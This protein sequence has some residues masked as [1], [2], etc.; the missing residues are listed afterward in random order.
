MKPYYEQDGITIY[1][2]DSEVMVPLL[3]LPEL[4]VTDPPYGIDY[5]S[6]KRVTHQRMKK[7]RGDKEFPRWVLDIAP[8]IALFI[9]CR[10]D[11]LLANM[12]APKSFIVWDKGV[13][14]M[15]DVCH[16]YGRQWEGCAFY[17]GPDHA[18]LKRPCDIIRINKIPP[19]QLCHPNEKPSAAI[20]PLIVAHRGDVLDPF[21]GSG[22][23]LVAAKALGRRATG[24]E[25]E[26]R[27][28]EI[29][30]QR[31]SQGVLF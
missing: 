28:C 8:S 11:V 4:V 6:N 14:A 5:Q 29:A 3:T 22:S 30:A 12:P 15:G 19:A 31:L 2:G 13:G 16:E 20:L 18:F 27:Y 10:W 26:E 9:W 7:I 21:M 23:T 24:I 1:H 25:V 17:P